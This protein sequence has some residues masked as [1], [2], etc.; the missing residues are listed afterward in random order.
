MARLPGRRPGHD[1]RLAWF[2]GIC[3][4]R[5]VSP[6]SVTESVRKLYGFE[7][8]PE[9]RDRLDSLTDSDYKR[10][11][12]VCGLLAEKGTGCGLVRGFLALPAL[13]QHVDSPEHDRGHPCPLPRSTTRPHPM[14]T[15]PR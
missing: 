6:P 3:G 15:R 11:D 9:V 14:R 12:E 7:L 1:T 2:S 10:A 4:D 8:E 13:P 5:P